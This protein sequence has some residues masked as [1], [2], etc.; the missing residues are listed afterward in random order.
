[1]TWITAECGTKVN[2]LTAST[3][4][5]T[6]RTVSKK[7]LDKGMRYNTY[8]FAGGSK[9]HTTDTYSRIP[10][11]PDIWEIK[12]LDGRVFISTTDPL[13]KESL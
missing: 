3:V 2:M 4:T 12:A 5:K 1:M 8:I 6:V 11:N 10:I 9:Y 7:Y 13:I